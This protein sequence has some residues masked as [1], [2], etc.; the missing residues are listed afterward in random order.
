MTLPVTKIAN[1]LAAQVHRKKEVAICRIMRRTLAQRVGSDKSFECIGDS[2]V[3]SST[4]NEGWGEACQP[5]R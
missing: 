4:V 2:R 3:F 1:R 5:T